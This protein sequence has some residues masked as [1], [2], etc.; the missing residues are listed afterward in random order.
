MAK[1]NQSDVWVN[2]LMIGNVFIWFD[3]A[4][5][6]IHIQTI[7]QYEGYQQVLEITKK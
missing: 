3:S 5:Y 7:A 2:I 6:H 4:Y 1:D